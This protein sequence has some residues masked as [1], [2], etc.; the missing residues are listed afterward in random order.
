MRAISGRA[1]SS[2]RRAVESATRA[3]SATSSGAPPCSA[4]L[5]EDSL[6]LVDSCSSHAS[7]QKGRVAASSSTTRSSARTPS[8][9]ASSVRATRGNSVSVRSQ[10]S[11][12]QR[13]RSSARCSPLGGSCHAVGRRAAKSAAVPRSVP[14]RSSA[15]V[16]TA[17]SS[18]S[19]YANSASHT[20]QRHAAVAQYTCARSSSDSRGMYATSVRRISCAYCWISPLGS[21]AVPARRASMSASILAVGAGASARSTSNERH[22]VRRTGPDAAQRSATSPH[23]STTAGWS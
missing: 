23:R 4:R 1:A 5:A 22:A 3:T 12:E 18:S 17:S 20:V 2:A 15:V 16:S 14:H 9:A 11:F 6:L 13:P 8:R 7:R 19:V 10:S 21:D